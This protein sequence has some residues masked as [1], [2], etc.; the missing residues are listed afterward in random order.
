MRGKISRIENGY[1]IIS[2]PS[3][4][5][6]F[7]SESKQIPCK[8]FSDY[9]VG[10]DVLFFVNN[11]NTD[12]KIIIDAEASIDWWYGNVYDI[13]NKNIY[14]M[15]HNQKYIISVDYPNIYRKNDIV[16][17]VP[18]GSSYKMKTVIDKH[19]CIVLNIN[20]YVANIEG[21]NVLHICITYFDKTEDKR[22]YLIVP[23]TFSI[24]EKLLLLAPNDNF[25]MFIKEDD[26]DPIRNIY[27]I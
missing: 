8:N 12:S 16:G 21:T 23:D 18:D 14:V 1:L 24:F 22:E 11:D 4:D 6:P 27:I 13:D 9:K 25:L 3:S 2:V 10:Q 15:Y 7:I 20:M 19:E 26:S 5:N 17:F